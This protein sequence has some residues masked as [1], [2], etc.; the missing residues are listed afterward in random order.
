MTNTATITIVPLRINCLRAC[1]LTPERAR[2]RPCPRLELT[3]T[4]DFLYIF[5]FPDIAALDEL[6]DWANS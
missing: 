2:L 5:F 3:S 1:R 4:T 6:S